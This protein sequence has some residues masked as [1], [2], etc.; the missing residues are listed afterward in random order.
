MVGFAFLLSMFAPDEGDELVKGLRRRFLV[1][2]SEAHF[3]GEGR[4]CG[5][6]WHW[7]CRE[8]DGWRVSDGNT[9]K[10]QAGVAGICAVALQ[11]FCLQTT[12]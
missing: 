3:G 4:E 7:F 10:L 6:G 11:Y 2:W 5:D 8:I 12:Q 9:L 1:G